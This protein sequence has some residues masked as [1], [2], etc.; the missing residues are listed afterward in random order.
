MTF[1]EFMRQHPSIRY[2][3]ADERAV[4]Y[5]KIDLQKLHE[6]IVR[7]SWLKRAVR[8][9]WLIRSYEEI[10]TGKYDDYP[11]RDLSDCVHFDSERRYTKAQ[12]DALI[13]D[14]DNIEF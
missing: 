11:K 1:T 7:S 9:S 14:I 13:D 3:R 12:L 5:Y 4:N 10:L 2:D 6:A 8:L